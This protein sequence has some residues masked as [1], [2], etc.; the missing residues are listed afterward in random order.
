MIQ[1]ERNGLRIIQAE[2]GYTLRK[3]GDEGTNF[4]TEI[5]LGKND[6]S[7]HYEEITIE[8]A[9]RLIEESMQVSET[10]NEENHGQDN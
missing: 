4:S 1:I 3:K 2:E 6:L 7:E 10:I 9:E 8:D 5:Y